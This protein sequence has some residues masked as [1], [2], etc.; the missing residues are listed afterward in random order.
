[1]AR[2]ISGCRKCRQIG[3]K[4]CSKVGR[5]AV[6]KR[7]TYPGQFGKKIGTK[8]LTE[9]GKQL[10][11]KQKV[12]FL[13]GVDEKQFR[14][15]FAIASQQKGVTGEILMSLLERRLDNTV[16]RLKMATS[17]PQARQMVAHG[18]VFVNGKR[19]KS[20][21]YIVVVGDEITL[22]KRALSKEAFI[23]NVVDK[24]MSIGIKVPEWLELNKAERKGIVLKEP[25]RMDV[26]VPVEEHL[27]V[28]LYSK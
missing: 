5:C 15:F 23:K 11:E 19:V 20:S 4:L 21:S 2:T 1:M 18:L 26:K 9:Y 27:I 6:E 17:R 13:Y 7:S 24:R 10:R 12:K 25:E 28:E 16:F 22:S 14:R 3:E 8:K